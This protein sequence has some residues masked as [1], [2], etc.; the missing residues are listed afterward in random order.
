MDH[1]APVSMRERK[2]T[3]L[4]KCIAAYNFAGLPALNIK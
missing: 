4:R 3:T 1:T 2:M